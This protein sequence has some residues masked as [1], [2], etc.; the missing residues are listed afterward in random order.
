MKSPLRFRLMTRIAQR[1]ARPPSHWR[2]RSCYWFRLWPWGGARCGGIPRYIR[3]PLSHLQLQFRLSRL[4]IMLIHIIHTLHHRPIVSSRGNF[5]HH[6]CT[7][8]Y[9]CTVY[10]FYTQVSAA[11]AAPGPGGSG[12]R[13]Q[14]RRRGD[15]EENY[16]FGGDSAP[17]ASCFRSVAG[18]QPDPAT[19]PPTTGPPSCPYINIYILYYNIIQVHTHTHI[20]IYILYLLS[21]VF[22][23]TNTLTCEHSRVHLLVFMALI[24]ID[25]RGGTHTLHQRVN[26]I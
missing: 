12:P 13:R 24:S 23:H 11:A 21:Q 4:L 2:S 6:R 18:N 7:K 25:D 22:A 20:H 10:A 15:P 14:R 8:N 19:W 17:A 5:P 16:F 1:S 26:Y 3:V 9:C